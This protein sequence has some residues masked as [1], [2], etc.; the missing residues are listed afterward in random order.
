MSANSPDNHPT[1]TVKP[2]AGGAAVLLVGRTGARSIS[3][4]L[5]LVL[6]RLLGPASYGLYA[7]GW[8]LLLIVG[9]AASLGL[10]H[11]V[12]RFGADL[13]TE[14]GGRLRRVTRRSL[15]IAA[16]AGGVAAAALWLLAPWLANSVFEK[17]DLRP[18]LAVMAAALLF[19][20]ALRVAA[21][22]LRAAL[23]MVP[24][25]IA[26]D[27]VQPLVNLVLFLVFWALGWHL[28]GAVVATDVSFAVALLA[29]LVFLARGW[30]QRPEPVGGV[31][32]VGHRELMLF[33]LP[34]AMAGMLALVTM[35]IDRLLVAYFLSAADTGI[36]QAASQ[37]AFIFILIL[38]SFN[39]IFAPL[40]SAHFAAGRKRELN[41]LYKVSTKWGLY[42]AMPVFLV[43]VVAPDEVL[44][45]LLDHRYVVGAVP[46]VVLSIAQLVN[47]ATGAVGF[48]LVMGGR[49][50]SWLLL[51]GVALAA[52]IGLSLYLIPLHGLVGAAVAALVSIVG[53][54][55]S[56]LL[57]VHR[58]EGLWPWDRRYVKGLV[59]ALAT[60]GALVLAN[61]LPIGS[62]PVHLLVLCVVAVVVF[63]AVLRVLGPDPEDREVMQLVRGKLGAANGATDGEDQQS[64]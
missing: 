14:D 24:N 31:P 21:A 38:N 45:V 8:N 6:G 28:I 50:N 15:K 39:G 32:V 34:A 4:I 59:A 57:L 64:Q 12:I 42:L 20:P 1:S 18:V 44:G 56:A 5:Q 29:A 7:V 48:I 52:N 35:W 13:S 22:S 11:G 25:V 26:E 33:S 55:G 51:S 63:A 47:L 40:I 37:V 23:R 30:R 61:L 62:Q 49:Q 17:P 36:Y 3:Y 10:E 58:W 43:V 2:L 19:M 9:L 54:F 60:A 41:D 53:L 16:L 46:L 27:L